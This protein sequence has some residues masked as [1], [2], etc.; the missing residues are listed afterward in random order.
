MIGRL[1]ARRMSHGGATTTAS[2]P[3]TTCWR[4]MPADSTPPGSNQ[5][6]LLIVAKSPIHL[7]FSEAKYSISIRCTNMY[8]LPTLLRKMRSTEYSRNRPY[9]NGALPYL[10]AMKHRVQCCTKNPPPRS[11]ATISPVETPTPSPVSK[12]LAKPPIR[13]LTIQ[14]IRLLTSPIPKPN[15]SP[16]TSAFNPERFVPSFG[17]DLVLISDVT[18]PRRATVIKMLVDLSPELRQTVKTH[19]SLNGELSHGKVSTEVHE[20]I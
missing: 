13:S 9:W 6:E 12:P 10:H 19:F 18:K 11:I 8:P 17:F 7:G 16:A 1:A 15:S 2:L 4:P 5:I 3:R 20:G 14:T